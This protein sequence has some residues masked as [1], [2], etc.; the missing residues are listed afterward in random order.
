VGGPIRQL[1]ANQD[2]HDVFVIAGGWLYWYSWAGARGEHQVLRVHRSG[3]EP[4][5]L[6]RAMTM[7]NDVDVAGNRVIIVPKGEG[8]VLE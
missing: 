4:E 7:P 1:A 5:V 3:G 6:V 8:T 2:N